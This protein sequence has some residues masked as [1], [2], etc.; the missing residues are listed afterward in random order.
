MSQIKVYKDQTGTPTLVEVKYN[1]RVYQAT[2]DKTAGFKFNRRNIPP[3]VIE[4]FKL[5]YPNQEKLN[6]D[7]PVP[8]PVV[9]VAGGDIVFF[10]DMEGL[11]K[12]NDDV[13]T[14][15]RD[16]AR[17]YNG[18]FSLRTTGAIGVLAVT[19]RYFPMVPS[20]KLEF[21]CVWGCT[22]FTVLDGVR[23][24]IDFYDGHHL[25]RAGVQYNPQSL[26]W[27]YVN[28]A[29]GYTDIPGSLNNSQYETL[30]VVA[31]VYHK[32]KFSAD[33]ANSRYL[34]F[35]ANEFT[36]N[37][38]TI[39]CYNVIT[40]SD[41]YSRAYMGVDPVVAQD[42]ICQFDDVLVKEVK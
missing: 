32:V 42:A 40:V 5:V 8:L 10:D 19:S 9:S 36:A 28:A 26:T 23:F 13:G 39:N 16:G 14:T 18:S 20:K 12:W 2:Y 24:T 4:L 37:L 29:N 17:A 3:A 34:S 41:R 11:L 21:S 25:V 7:I 30:N 33:F 6:F 15:V 27:Q 1:N 31:G 22:D 38:E 35:T